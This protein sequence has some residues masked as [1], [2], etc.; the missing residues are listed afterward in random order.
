MKTQGNGCIRLFVGFFL[1]FGAVGGL[2]TTIG[3]EVEQVSFA[4]LGMAIAA[5]GASDIHRNTR[6][7]L[8]EFN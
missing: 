8:K 3:H 4:L 7:T 5:W 2:E 6:D 1:V